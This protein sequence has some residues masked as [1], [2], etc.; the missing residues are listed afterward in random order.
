MNAANAMVNAVTTRLN[1]HAA[2]IEKLRLK[3]EYAG[4]PVFMFELMVIMSQKTSF[5]IRKGSSVLIQPFYSGKFSLED[6]LQI[7]ESTGR[8]INAL[9]ISS[10]AAYEDE[11]K[12]LYAKLKSN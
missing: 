8:I 4:A 2:D 12:T 3:C 1:Q 7:S 5:D 6:A 9:H 11:L 10:V